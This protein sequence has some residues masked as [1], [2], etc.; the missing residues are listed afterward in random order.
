V[1]DSRTLREMLSD[2]LTGAGHEV[3]TARDG[4]EGLAVL[5]EYR[6]DIVITDLNMPVMDGIEFI[7][8]ART[9]DAGRGVPVLLL[10]TEIAGELKLRARAAGATG[11]LTKP[12]DGVHVLG[13]IDQLA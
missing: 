5:R 3:M 1:D 12:F 7:T 4:A 6:P 10:T 13:L 8:A 9:E 2:C 11:W